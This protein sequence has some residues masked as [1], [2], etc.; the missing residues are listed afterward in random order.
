M[1]TDRAAPEPALLDWLAAQLDAEGPFEIQ[2]I[3]GGNSNET[4]LLTAPAG[5]WI[6][7]RPPNAVI[8][9]TAN[10]LGR[11]FRILTA[12][13]G[14]SVPVPR[15]IAFAPAGQAT[16]RPCLL[17]EYSEGYPLTDRWP[18]WPQA[19]TIGQVGRAAIE[20]LAALHQVDF[21]AAGLA[22]FG[23]AGYLERQVARWRGQYEQHRVRDLPLFDS[24]GDWLEAN[25]PAEGPPTILHG[26]F[27]LDNCLITPGP[28]ARVSA[29]IDWELATVGDPLVDLGLLLGFWGTDRARP[30]AM[31]R[32]QALSR[33]PGAPGRRALADYY[34]SLTGRS[35]QALAFYMVLALF[36]LAAI[37]EGAY[38]RYLGRDVD[39]PYARAL[40]A[41][42]PRL[43]R[44][45]AHLAGTG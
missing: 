17:M 42:V 10:D 22:G 25:R 14:R 31:E 27:H 11:E 33:L 24:L 4:S 13:A 8:S 19:A 1:T 3:S 28:P 21:E 34:T 18:A 44:D 36:K 20:A 30:I 40:G 7:R 45:A 2:S 43:L 41:D 26:D 23:A 6:L 35:T 37:V 38:A 5:R 12:L 9:A 32:V 15:A 29:I 16:D 39:S